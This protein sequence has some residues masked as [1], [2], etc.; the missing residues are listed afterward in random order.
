MT[1]TY[2]A[3]GL[4]LILIALTTVYIPAPRTELPAA[5]RQAA[6]GAAACQELAGRWV[7]LSPEGHDRAPRSS[8]VQIIDLGADGTFRYEVRSEIETMWAEG[9][10]SSCH[11]TLRFRITA[12]GFPEGAGQDVEARFC[13]VGSYL[14]LQTQA[15]GFIVSC[16]LARI[17]D[18][19]V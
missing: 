4:V 1:T 14:R 7:R 10:Y 11:D 17:G 16:D 13:L 2:T 9:T 8:E 3:V 18:A 12:S 6:A 5:E 19:P 15:P